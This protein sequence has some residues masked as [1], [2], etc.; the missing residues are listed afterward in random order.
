MR[1][2]RQ[3]AFEALYRHYAGRVLRLADQ[4]LGGRAAADDAAQ[5]TFIRVFRGV[6]RFRGDSGLGTW[7]HRI[8][9][10]VCLSE[11]TRRGRRQQAR[12]EGRAERAARPSRADPEAAR[13]AALDLRPL[14]AELEPVKRVTFYLHHV[15]GCSA[16]EVARI[17]GHGRQAVLKRL[18]RTRRELVL[19]VTGAGAPGRDEERQA[20]DG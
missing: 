7:I 9:V 13:A 12:A 1:E 17:L 20:N 18:Q 8:A 2:G 3:G 11:L 5:E 15:E 14:L 10:N 4:M 16:A 19:A 6:H